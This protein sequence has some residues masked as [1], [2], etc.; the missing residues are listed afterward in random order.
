MGR[1]G[2][3]VLLEATIPCLPGWSSALPPY[4]G[5]IEWKAHRVPALLG[6]LGALFVALNSIAFGFLL[7]VIALVYGGYLS[8]ASMGKKEGIY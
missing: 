2:R 3:I 6:I 5:L 7:I 8:D 4:E 1:W